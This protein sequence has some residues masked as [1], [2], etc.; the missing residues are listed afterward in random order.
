MKDMTCNTARSDEG[1]AAG[2]RH[3]PP[4]PHASAKTLAARPQALLA[5]ETQPP[6]AAQR[7]RAG[8]GRLTRRVVAVSLV[9]LALWWLVVPLAFPVT[10]EAVVNAR[11]VQVRAPIEGA[12]SELLHDIGDTVAA[13]QP[14]ARLTNRRVDAS[15]LSILTTRHA[16]VRARHKRLTAEVAA[17]ARAEA[18]CRELA[19]RYQSGQVAMLEASAAETTARIEAARSQ[20]AG[21]DILLQ[22]THKLAGMK[23]AP[24]SDVDIA[25]A[26]V[27]AAKKNVHQGEASLAKTQVALEAARAGLFLE[28]EAPFFLQRADE[29]ALKLPVLK[30]NLTEARELL[31]ALDLELKRERSRIASLQAATVAAPVAGVVWNCQRNLGQIVKPNE[32]VYE[33]ADTGTVFVEALL[34]QR[35][36]AAIE[37]GSTATILVTGGTVYTG[38]VRAVRTSGPTDSETS[39]ALKLASGDMKQA[40]VLIDFAYG[41]GTP[42]LIG[43]HARVLITPR[44]P[45]AVRGLVACVFSWMGG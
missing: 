12:T 27:V 45:G 10:S 4:R 28:H 2:H 1:D 14:L 16:E 35:H 31:A 37:V 36:L 24:L 23:A 22:R 44:E 25:R 26:T 30:A 29:L 18:L 32:T 38:R 11:L 13:G 33:V 21:S 43:R 15:H 41:A 20:H 39:Y 42:D 7:W 8:L 17:V 34:H 19:Q 40:R 3:R 9:A 5:Q 6:S